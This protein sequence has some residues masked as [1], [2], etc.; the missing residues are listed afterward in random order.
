VL[1]AWQGAVAFA[2]IAVLIFL[3]EQPMPWLKS[4]VL[5]G[6]A[7]QQATSAAA[8][9]KCDALASHPRDPGR[10]SAG[11]PDDQLAPGAAIE[12]CR[13]AVELDPDEPRL[14]FELG[15]AYWS[16]KRDSEAFS[17]FV[18][19]AQ[20]R[21]SPAMKYIGDAF[22]EGRGLPAGESQDV[23][24]AMRWYREACG[25]PCN[26]SPND[27]GYNVVGFPDAAKALAEAQE[28]MKKHELDASIFQNPKFI[29]ALY[30]GHSDGLEQKSLL[31][32]TFGLVEELG[33]DKILYV[34]SHCKPLSTIATQFLS[35]AG[36]VL[37]L[38]SKEDDKPGSG[39]V[40]GYIGFVVYRDQGNRDAVTLVNSYGCESQ[41]AKTIM[42]N[43]V[44]NTKKLMET[45]NSS[46]TQTTRDTNAGG[47][48]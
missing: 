22:L 33:G 17:A 40:A 31:A 12:A 42:N 30:S 1:R 35:G 43:I 41:V 29:S 34:D 23:S 14:R 11:V 24:V 25:R 38:F 5:S 36:A 8:V 18:S 20:R 16:A 27:P 37:S 21:Y 3:Y 7:A 10:Y 13:S 9:Q 48:R 44:V 46:S 2:I 19:A 32:Y 47:G 45:I 15:R 6:G 39:I 28:Y 4:V 26:P